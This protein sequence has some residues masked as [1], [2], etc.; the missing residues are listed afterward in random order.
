MRIG[1]E[2]LFNVR[3]HS[4]AGHVVVHVVLGADGVRVEITDDGTGFTVRPESSQ[5]GHRGLATMVDRASVSGGWCRIASDERGTVVRFW[6]PYAGT[7]DQG[8]PTRLS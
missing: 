2:A 1:K 3:E 6:M 7:S 4:G 5:P 8:S